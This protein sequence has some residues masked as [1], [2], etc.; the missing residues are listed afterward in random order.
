MSLS[1]F[2]LL[3]ALG[4]AMLLGPKADAEV[5]IQSLA[6]IAACEASA[7]DSSEFDQDTNRTDSFELNG[8][9]TASLVAGASGEVP[10]FGGTVVNVADS[11]MNTEIS[12]NAS[13]A[14]ARFTGT[15]NA[16]AGSSKA[17]ETAEGGIASSDASMFMI[18][19]VEITED[20]KTL[21]FEPEV[22]QSATRGGQFGFGSAAIFCSIRQ[23]GETIGV[24]ETTCTTTDC[25]PEVTPLRRRLEPGVYE[26]EVGVNLSAS[27]GASTNVTHASNWTLTL[28]DPPSCD[29]TWNEFGSGGLFSDPDNWSPQQAP[30]DDGS[31]CNNLL[32]SR[33]GAFTVGVSGSQAA[34]SLEVR[35]P[36]MTLQSSTGGGL[37]LSA[38]V[39][40]PINGLQV[41]EGGGLTVNGVKLAA[42]GVEV[43]SLIGGDGAATLTLTGVATELISRGTTPADP[44]AKSIE[45]GVNQQ[46]T[47]DVLNGAVVSAGKLRVG[48]SLVAPTQN[49]ANRGLLNIRGKSGTQESLVAFSDETII[50]FASEGF[51]NVEQGGRFAGGENATLVIGGSADATLAVSGLN[52]ADEAPAKVEVR[53]ALLIGGAANTSATA[54]VSDQGLITADTIEL[55]ERING[56]SVG[57]GSLFIT[58]GGRVEVTNALRINGKT[59]SKLE[60]GS[61]GKLLLGGPLNVGFGS[62]STGRAEI[63]GD[64]ATT[65]NLT[66]TAIIVGGQFGT[67]VLD[68]SGNTNIEANSLIVPRIAEDTSTGNGTVAISDGALVSLS[69]DV[70]IG[71][72]G[73]GKVTLAGP[74]V[75]TA[76]VE[77]EIGAR[78]RLEVGRL[79]TVIGPR[80]RV[81]ARGGR[82][83][84]TAQRG[85]QGGDAPG[86]IQGDLELIEGGVLELEANASG[87]AALRVEGAF[88]ADG[89]LEVV[90]PDAAALA[91]NDL[92]TLLEV[93]GTT[94]GAFDEVTSP[95]RTSDFAATVEVDGGEVRVR[96]V[97]PGQPIATVDGEDEGEGE[98]EVVPPPAGC[99]C[100]PDGKALAT[101][102]PWGSAIT[103]LLAAAALLG[104]ALQRR[105]ISEEH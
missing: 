103:W 65:T 85:K 63:S 102:T 20:A 9:F 25:P 30:Q 84:G 33:N 34:N 56:A 31:G 46:G 2:S 52:T 87:D 50:G 42:S 26:I 96:I 66:G 38:L 48:A 59:A 95:S 57:P 11:A 17:P 79:A 105:R 104:A 67:G 37:T 68:V 53:S 13:A 45:I 78:G 24:A 83:V 93:T 8:N 6:R 21:S 69:N 40:T 90:F 7:S 60:L 61:G 76:N 1:R 99:G 16:S 88:T 70:I 54:I 81:I 49:A 92:L 41:G 101:D 91:A 71:D 86:T 12:V 82:V 55:G 18:L 28:S 98:G 64:S 35:A 75:L 73:P 44:D 29:L 23:N 43:G 32:I 3:A 97:N 100:Q 94:Q 22:T 36:S 58:L 89:T 15:V 4:A 51:V 72:Q 5:I 77:V 80:V 19:G 27:G 62:G 10:I 74:S 47:V 39:G 14:E